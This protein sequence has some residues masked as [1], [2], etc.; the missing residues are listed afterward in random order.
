[1]AST[2]TRFALE[3]GATLRLVHIGSQTEAE[4]VPAISEAIG[5]TLIVA[6]ANAHGANPGPVFEAAD[7]PVMLIPRSGAQDAPKRR[8][9]GAPR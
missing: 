7:I 1:M 5:A 8:A 6:S 3:L 9:T 2:A 4:D